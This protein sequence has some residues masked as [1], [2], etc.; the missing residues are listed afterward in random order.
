MKNRF[1]NIALLFLIL[2]CAACNKI[3]E[4]IQQ[5][6]LITDTFDFEIPVIDTTV[7]VATIPGIKSNLDLEN[8]LSKSSNNFTMAN[9]KATKIT[10]LNVGLLTRDGKMDS[11]NNF[12]QLESV[13]FRIAANGVIKQMASASIASSGN[14]GAIPFVLS[15]PADSLKSFLTSPRTYNLVVRIKKATTAVIRA[16]ATA[17]YT[18]T[19][20]K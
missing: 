10:S 4:N 9:L 19:L 11:V 20:A 1:L 14:V 8:E 18:I 7:K 17:S 15:I 5:D 12:G 13:R 6:I 3:E 16:R 2:A